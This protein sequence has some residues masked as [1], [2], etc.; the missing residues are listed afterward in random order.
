MEGIVLPL[1]LLVLVHGP[2]GITEPR[3]SWGIKEKT[4]PNILKLMK[5]ARDNSSNKQPP[6]KK[7]KLNVPLNTTS[8][9]YNLRRGETKS[10]DGRMSVNPDYNGLIYSLYTNVAAG[11]A[12]TQGTTSSQYLGDSITPLFV[13]VRLAATVADSYNIVSYVLLQMIGGGTLATATEVYQSTGNTQAPLSAIT[14]TRK[15]SWNILAHKTVYLDTYNA[16][17]VT[18]LKVPISRLVDTEFSDA[19][20][21]VNSGNIY[22]AII[23]D[24]AAVTHP[25]VL[26]YW[27]VTYSDK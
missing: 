2:A 1:H 16:V 27:R 3:K 9:I 12:I 24:S 20:G 18:K 10:Y 26:G 8:S 7:R 11:T 14:K 17:K 6:T 23:S 22:L 19:A 4:I 5:R 21:T 25:G 13:T 15:K